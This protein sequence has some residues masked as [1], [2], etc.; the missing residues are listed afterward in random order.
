MEKVNLQSA[1]IADENVAKLGE[2]FPDVV[3]EVREPDG[4]LRHTIDV[5]ALKARVGD[6]AEGKRE[7]YQFTWPG[8][9]DARA[10][11][12]RPIDKTLRPCKDKSVNWDTTEN[13]YIEGDNLDA[14]KILRETYAGKIKMIYID[15]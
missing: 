2:L 9:Q 14:L 6:V 3:T 13:L 4:S 1:N 15:P 11:A 5:E 12:I 8:K 10:E 7:R